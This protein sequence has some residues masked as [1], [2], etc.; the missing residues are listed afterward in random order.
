MLATEQNLITVG[1]RPGIEVVWIPRRLT[2][3]SNLLKW[4]SLHAARTH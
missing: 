1:V 3:F 4:D 2:T